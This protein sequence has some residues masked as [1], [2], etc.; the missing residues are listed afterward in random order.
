MRDEVEIRKEL[1]QRQQTLSQLV[2]HNGRDFLK[3]GWGRYLQTVI[4]DMEWVLE[5]SR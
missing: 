4:Q 2:H 1:E 5:L 3:T